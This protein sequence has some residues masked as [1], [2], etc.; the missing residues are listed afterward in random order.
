MTRKLPSRRGEG[1]SRSIQ[2]ST[3]LRLFVKLEG[4]TEPK[5]TTLD[6]E[7]RNTN[8]PPDLINREIHQV[9]GVAV[10]VVDGEREKGVATDPTKD[11]KKE[12][13]DVI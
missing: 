7:R 8:N 3:T 5:P 10:K 1:R 4:N 11:E 9:W 12:E 6:K 13:G 2:K